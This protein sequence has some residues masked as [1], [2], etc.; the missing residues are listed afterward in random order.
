MSGILSSEKGRLENLSACSGSCQN[1]TRNVVTG[2]SPYF[3]LFDREPRLFIDVGFCLQR[4]GQKLPPS[5]STYVKLLRGGLGM[6]IRKHINWPP[7]TKKDTRGCMTRDA[8]GL[9]KGRRHSFGSINSVE[10]KAE[11]SGQMGK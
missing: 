10:R 1:C 6:P 4:S 2:Y 5:K 7:N 9:T 11:K 3:L 8:G